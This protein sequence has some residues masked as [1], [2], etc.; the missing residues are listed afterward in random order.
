[1]LL[2]KKRR[3]VIFTAALGV[4]VIAVAMLQPSAQAGQHGTNMCISQTV[5]VHKS[6]NPRSEVVGT[7]DGT[8]VWHDYN[9][10]DGWSLGYDRT[11]AQDLRGWIPANVLTRDLGNATYSGTC[12]KGADPLKDAG[13]NTIAV[14]GGQP[15]R[16]L[17]LSKPESQ[18]DS[19]MVCVK[20]VTVR[21]PGSSHPNGMLYRG[22]HFKI[23]RLSPSGKWALGKAM[24]GED[25]LGTVMVN[26]LA[27][28]NGNCPHVN[29]GK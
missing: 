28:A 10:K 9:R 23:D 3:A 14:Q 15:D 7:M 13:R 26:S 5:D 27:D 12:P 17:V 20:N 2:K 19:R 4:G 11:H 25:V 24:G 21:I 8:A 22:E 6:A 16:P 1:M 29:G 18:L